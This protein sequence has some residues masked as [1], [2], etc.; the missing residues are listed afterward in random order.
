MLEPHLD[1]LALLP[2]LLEALGTGERTGNITGVLMD[3]ARDLARWVFRTALW[4]EWAYIAVELA[5][6]IQK[7]LAFMYGA[8]CPKLLAAGAMIDVVGPVILKVAA[9]E[10]AVIPLRFVEHGDMWRDALLL[11]QPVQHRTAP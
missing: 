10:G 6:A 2:R 8:A 3:V 5:G 9:R 11:D 7:R 1:L 4:F